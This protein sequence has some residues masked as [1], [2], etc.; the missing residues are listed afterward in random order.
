MLFV[1][2]K[3][4]FS[5]SRDRTVTFWVDNANAGTLK[6]FLKTP[7]HGTDGAAFL[8]SSFEE[9]SFIVENLSKLIT[10]PN[11]NFIHINSMTR[12][13]TKCKIETDTACDEITECGI[14][15]GKE[16]AIQQLSV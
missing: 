8:V 11:F 1:T 13:V 7:R 9:G 3:S 10:D 14:E 12:T 15:E 16:D 4:A 6:V 5:C 2:S